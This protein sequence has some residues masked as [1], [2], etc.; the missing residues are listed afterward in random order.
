MG[1]F[2]TLLYLFFDFFI[3]LQNRFEFKVEK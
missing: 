3:L 2:G 1:P